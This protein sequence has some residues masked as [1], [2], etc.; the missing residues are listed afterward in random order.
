[1]LQRMSELAVQAANGTLSD[2]DRFQIN[3]EFEQLKEEISRSANQTEFNTKPLLGKDDNEIIL[4]IGAN[5]GQTMTIKLESMTG[6][7]LNLDDIDISTQKNASKA[8]ERLQEAVKKTS[9]FR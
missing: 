7:A 5:T 8:I 3:K 2:D 6:S 1:M 4:Q 9:S